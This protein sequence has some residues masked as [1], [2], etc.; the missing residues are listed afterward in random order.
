MEHSLFFVFNT[1]IDYSDIDN[2]LEIYEKKSGKPFNGDYFNKNMLSI[3]KE[4]DPFG[5]IHS[6]YKVN[7][8]F[9]RYIEISSSILPTPSVNIEKYKNDMIT[10]ILS[11]ENDPFDAVQLIED[12]MFGKYDTTIQ[13]IY[14]K[15]CSS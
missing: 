9:A 8:M 11:S 10:K 2:A 7:S 3:L 4:L 14:Y 1:C 15:T 6:L 13:K 5:E 12:I